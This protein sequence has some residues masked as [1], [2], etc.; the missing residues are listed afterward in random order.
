MLKFS[1]IYVTIPFSTVKEGKKAREHLF[2]RYLAFLIGQKCCMESL[3]GNFF[4][5][6]I[7]NFWQIVFVI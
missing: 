3:F 1:A 7:Q 4:K 5:F 2:M 6:F